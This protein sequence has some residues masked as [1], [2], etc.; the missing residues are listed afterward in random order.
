[1]GEILGLDVRDLVDG[2]GVRRGEGGGKEEGLGERPGVRGLRM[3]GKLVSDRGDWLSCPARRKKLLPGLEL[4]P[5]SLGLLTMPPLLFP[6]EDERPARL[7]LC[8][9]VRAA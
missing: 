7:T 3:S 2:V 6:P 5:E 4:G 9:T 8:I 1:M